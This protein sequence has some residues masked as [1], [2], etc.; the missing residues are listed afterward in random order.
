[1]SIRVQVVYEFPICPWML[2]E[3]IGSCSDKAA[4]KLWRSV[5][6]L[7]QGRDDESLVTMNLQI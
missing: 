2:A 6:L 7:C 1:M 5:L 4:G 3:A